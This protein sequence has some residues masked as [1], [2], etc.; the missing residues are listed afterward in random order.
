[1]EIQLCKCG[2]NPGLAPEKFDYEE[3]GSM[4]KIISVT[5]ICRECSE[6]FDLEQQDEGKWT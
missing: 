4:D 1:M 2:Y 5:A 3:F 6:K